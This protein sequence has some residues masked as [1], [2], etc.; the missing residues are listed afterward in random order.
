MD[1][2]GAPIGLATVMTVLADL[3]APRTELIARL[4]EGART[5]QLEV[6]DGRE[7][8]WLA[9]LARLLYGPNGPTIG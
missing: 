3:E 9:E 5:G 4:A 1:D 7:E 8:A 6:R 2:T